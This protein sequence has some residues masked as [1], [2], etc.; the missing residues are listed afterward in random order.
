MSHGSRKEMVRSMLG[1]GILA[2]LLGMTFGC[3]A[4]SPAGPTLT[5]T[6]T[7]VTPAPVATGMYTVT[8]GT[9]LVAPGGDVSVSWTAST[10][11]RLDWISLFPVGGPNTVYSSYKYTD[12]ATFGTFTISAPAQPGHHEVRYLLNDGYRDVARSGPVTVGAGP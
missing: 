7:P 8:A 3:G 10:G 12:G 2:A 9:D 1:H 4:S 5:I 11:G 6:P